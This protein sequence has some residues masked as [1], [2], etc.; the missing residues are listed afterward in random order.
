MDYYK[1]KEEAQNLIRTLKEKKLS[2]EEIAEA[3][4]NTFLLTPNWTKKYYK[5]LIK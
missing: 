5:K 4:E 1:R 3:V 2:I